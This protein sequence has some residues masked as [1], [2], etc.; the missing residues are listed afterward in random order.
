VYDKKGVLDQFVENRSPFKAHRHRN[1]QWF[2]GGTFHRKVQWFRGGLVFEAHRLLYHNSRLESNKEEEEKQVTFAPFFSPSHRSSHRLAF[3]R[4]FSRFFLPTFLLTC[5]PFFSN[6]HLSSHLLTFLPFHLP[7]HLPTASH[8]YGIAC[9]LLYLLW[10]PSPQVRSL[11]PPF[12][13]PSHVSS[14]SPFFSTSHLSAQ[15]LTL[16]PSRLS[17]RAFESIRKMLARA[18][19]TGHSF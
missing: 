10:E 19:D 5:S 16:L 4:T 15:L 11:S 1:V 6:S 9:R 8:L 17:Y 14:I 7:S 18:A 3:L 2:R 12:F 13:S